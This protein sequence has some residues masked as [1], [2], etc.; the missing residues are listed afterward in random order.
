MAQPQLRE[1]QS[2]GIHGNTR[3]RRT[4][5]KVA[6]RS[7]IYVGRGYIVNKGL[8]SI[9][10]V[11]G[12]RLKTLAARMII[13]VVAVHAILLP[14]VFR[15]VLHLVEQSHE[16]M[17]IDHV[18]AFSRFLVDNFKNEG[19]LVSQRR[20]VELLESATLAS[21]CVYAELWEGR[22]RLYGS[23]LSVN[24]SG[25]YIEDFAFN[26]NDDRIYFL[27]IPVMV[28]QHNITLRLGF[29][30]QPALDQIRLAYQKSVYYFSVYVI[31][32]LVLVIWLSIRLTRPLRALQY[33]SR[34][35]ASGQFDK[36]LDTD[37]TIVEIHE[38]AK[39]LEIMRQELVGTTENLKA[40]IKQRQALEIRR[41]LLEKQLLQSQKLEMVGALAGGIAHEFN[42]ILLPIVL[43]TEIVRDGLPPDSKF[44]QQLKRVLISANRAKELIAQILT[45]SRQRPE[46]QLEPIDLKSIIAESLEML[47]AVIPTTIE[48]SSDLHRC[49]L[50]LGD[51]AQIQQLIVNLCNNASKAIDRDSGKIVVNLVET[52]DYPGESKRPAS[53]LDLLYARLTVSDSGC[54]IDPDTLERIYEPF[55]TTAEVGQGSGLGLSVVHGIVTSHSGDIRVSSEV[56]SGTLVEVYLPIYP[57]NNHAIS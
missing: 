44:S 51:A 43:Y 35:I 17:F 47:R 1:P 49:G 20:A 32:S 25:V 56:G 34:E 33:A 19:R 39:D 16:E 23:E 31:V 14:L 18:R 40:E 57:S 15:E 26:Y 21:N 54:G 36:H 28:P 42:N 13:V 3:I 53:C 11:M 12:K 41:T 55:F 37:S 48:M 2:F 27:S 38:M 8:E 9:G 4:V 24:A 29:D 7:V 45:F 52:R 6:L 22:K 46:K 5:E 50:I 10:F 30:E